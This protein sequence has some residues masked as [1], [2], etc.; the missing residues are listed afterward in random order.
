MKFYGIKGNKVGYVVN[1][2]IYKHKLSIYEKMILEL[3]IT[4]L[5][6][7]TSK[8]IDSF[9]IDANYSHLSDINGVKFNPYYWES[10]DIV[11]KYDS[12]KLKALSKYIQGHFDAKGLEICSAVY[13][14]DY[15]T[16]YTLN[17]V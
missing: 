12:S 8:H 9:N 16:C 6:D 3:F 10:E 11:C 7:V 2:Y 15:L 17:K 4:K 5:F 14:G 1:Q 13:D